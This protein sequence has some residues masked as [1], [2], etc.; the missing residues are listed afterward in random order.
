MLVICNHEIAEQI[1][2]PSLRWSSSTPK[3]PTLVDIQALIGTHSI[4]SDEV[5]LW[6]QLEHII[7]L[8]K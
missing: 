6:A 4:I 1:S 3:S 8:R 5:S 2:K 7:L